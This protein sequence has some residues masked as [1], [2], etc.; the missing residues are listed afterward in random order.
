[1]KK[2][3]NRK[4][5]KNNKNK[6]YHEFDIYFHKKFFQLHPALGEVPTC[7]KKKKQN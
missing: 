4:E 3:S 5:K 1:M 7:F 2:I 6:K